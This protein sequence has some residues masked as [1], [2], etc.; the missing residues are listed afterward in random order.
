M[1]RRT[2]EANKAIAKAWENERKNILE[3]KGTRDWTPEQQKDILE[4]GKAHD[5][6]GRS[7]EGQHMKCVAE[8]PEYQGD[9]GNIQFLTREEHL[10]AHQGSWQNPTNWY[11]DPVTKEIFDFGSNPYIPCKVF[12]LEYPVVKTN[13]AYNDNVESRFEPKDKP[14]CRERTVQTSTNSVS[15]SSEKLSFFSRAKGIVIGFASQHP[16]LTTVSVVATGWVIDRATGGRIV[17]SSHSSDSDYD[18]SSADGEDL[19]DRSSPQEHMVTGHT[20][21]YH[22]KEG[23]ITKYKDPYPR[24]GTKEE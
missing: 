7:F 8:Y 17:S 14:S 2:S 21:R 9:P 19:T 15:A 12:E 1:S 24:G 5:E 3:G 11:Y 20:Q 13:A 23:T 6:N 22:T 10:E 18:Y 4:N 16:I